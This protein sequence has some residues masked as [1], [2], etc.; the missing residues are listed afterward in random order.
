MTWRWLVVTIGVL[1]AGACTREVSAHKQNAFKN[2]SEK[3]SYALGMNLAKQLKSKSIAVEPDVLLRGLKDSLSGKALLTDQE[4]RTVVASVQK[5]YNAKMAGLQREKMRARAEYGSER[6]TNRLAVSFKLDPRLMSGVYGGERWVSP[7]T[8]T[9][10]GEG[11]TCT[12]DARVRRL[13]ADGKPTVAQPTWTPADPDMVSVTIKGTDGEAASD[14]TILVR[15][16]GE[17]TLTVS[18]DGASKELAIKAVY[19]N[20]ILQVDISSK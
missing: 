6:G 17:T 12:I 20:N 5:D 4:L 16:A 15:R 2:E 19:R 9:R 13:D 3:V 1:A 11:K 10:V 14:A 8:Y 18:D 7:P